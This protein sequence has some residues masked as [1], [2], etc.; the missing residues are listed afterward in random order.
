MRLFEGTQF[1]IPPTCDRCGKLEE[2]C[3]CEP[4]PAPMLDPASQRAVV[5][6]EKRKRGKLVTLV[7]GLDSGESD[8]P[9]LL[10]T[11]KG[12]CGAGGTLK[13][14]IIEIQGD[15]Q[16]RVAAKLAEIG[17]RVKTR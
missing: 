16:Q 15:Q 9:A 14:D 5:R 6:T 10:T 17:Y 13:N 2:E 12:I 11:L 3:N 1:D 7:E 8:L 4:E